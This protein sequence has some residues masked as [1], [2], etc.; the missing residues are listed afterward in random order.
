MPHRA[1]ALLLPLALA[2]CLPSLAAQASHVNFES[3]H[4]HPLELTPD[5]SRLLA[6]NT[7]DARLQVY[8]VSGPSVVPVAAIAVGL[9]P[10]S[11][12]ARTSTE[13]WVVNHISD[14][15]SIVDLPTGRVRATLATDDEPCDVVFAGVPQRAFVSC[16]QANTVLV[17]DP[18]NLAA[19]PV[20]IALD[21]EDP[22]ALAVSANGLSVYVAV[23][24]S[25]NGSTILGGGLT[26]AGG[27]PPNVVS[28][29]AGPYGG[30]NPPPNAGA[31]FV[32]AQKPGNPAPPAVGLIV[33]KNAAGQWMDDNNGNWTALVS[34]AQAAKSGRVV[35]WDLPDRDVAVIDT[36][37]LGVSW[38]SRLMNIN[39]AL[40]VQPGTGRLAM[41]GTDGTN[42]KRFEPNLTGTFVRVLVALVDPAGTNKNV[43][44][45]NP[46]LTYAVATIP[47]A[48]RDTSIGDPRGIAWNA[49]GTRAYVT[50][51]GSNNV[52][53]IDAAGARA[54]LSPTIE[55][56][57]GPTG[58][59]LQE[60]AARA[61]VLNKFEG[62]LSVISLATETETAR[63]PWYDGEGPAIKAGRTFLYGTHE[64]SGLGQV[65]C[66]SC[67][68]D[69]RMDRL[70]WDLGDPA[71]DMKP[72]GEQNCGANLPGIG[73]GCDPWHPM[74]GPMLTQSLQDIIQKEPHHWRGDRD[75]LEEFNGA[76]VG[77][78]GDDVQ[79]TPTQMQQYEDFLATL[80]YPPNPF[81]NF[82]NTL[83]TN[84]A[85][86]DHLT[87]GDFGPAGQPLPNGNAATGLV[88]YRPPNLLDGGAVACST[89]HTLPTG[90]GPNVVLAG[91][92]FQ[93][94][95]PG[96]NGELRH[97][98]VSADGSTNISI[99]IPQLR[100]LHERTGFNLLKTSN[101][102][103]FGYLHDGS[104]DTIERFLGEPAFVFNSDQDIANMT[105]F[106][107]AFAGSDLPG[108]SSNPLNLEPPGP[109]ARDAHAAVGRQTTLLALAGAPAAQ[110]ALINSMI[111]IATANKV[112][113][114]A[115]W[116]AGG[117]PRGAR[118]GPGANWQTDRAAQTLSTAALQAL[119]APG[120][121]VTFTVVA[122]G[123]ETRLGIDRDLDGVLDADELDGCSNP[124]NP[125]SKPGNWTNLGGALAGLTGLPSLSGCGSLLA[126]DPVT[127][128]LV[129]ARPN[130]LTHL[131][132]GASALNAPFKGGTLVPAPDFLV[133]NLPTGPAG[134]LTL[135]APL[136][137]GLPA[138][139]ALHF[140][141]WIVDATGPFGF[142][143]SN[144][145]RGI[146]P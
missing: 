61:F 64:T 10:V 17:F 16:S 127:L 98:L 30:V 57:T 22:R 73:G 71:G 38:V 2:V 75:G 79:L 67:H 24:E 52:V 120:S 8:D 102:A 49:A 68:V 48:Q 137:G 27:F 93:T 33:K 90:I 14:S 125:A 11:V 18:A 78:Q 107:L 15:V 126:G 130:S 20:R 140:Q 5:G 34:G 87:T 59:V 121:E 92:S 26:M 13:A 118:F 47:Q 138:G 141:H 66:A 112:G 32:P 1:L 94:L 42:E 43:V 114:I 12:R 35:G 77:L 145:L 6:V 81:R 109:S 113:L 96:P 55:V 56:G 3:P 9:D 101:R 122:K 105:A 89:C 82:D 80:H 44:D 91:F 134:T 51:M 100:N 116:T 58:I 97:A 143:A 142:A 133:I 70:S 69:A 95:P 50:G 146:T 83:P 119:A 132:I 85:L 25:G 124:A 23:F 63:L 128:A 46:H 28:D 74:K 123:T 135:S 76:F 86:G 60:S 72:I 41:V 36:A 54:G 21:A 129:N 103:G 110:T 104:V 19:A 136:P 53:V 99:K 39:M 65:A 117:L 7:P 108:G 84:L 139:F 106:M 37:T 62:G 111:S 31:A 88:R 45:L 144:G 131:V 115:K 40:S 29:P 4:V